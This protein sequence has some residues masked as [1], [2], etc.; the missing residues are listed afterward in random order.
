MCIEVATNF[1]GRNGIIIQLNNTGSGYVN[2]VAAFGC[3]WL[4]NHA[5]EEE[6]LFIGGKH[7]VKIESIRVIQTKQ[8]FFRFLKALTYF[9]CML[10]GT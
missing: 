5:G 9:D 10:N 3:K 8:N 2:H 7:T 4:S 6:W 1:A